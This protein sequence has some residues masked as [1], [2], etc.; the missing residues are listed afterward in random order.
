MPWKPD[1][2]R[3]KHNKSLTPAQAKHA[4]AQANAI[5]RSGGDEGVAIATANKYAKRHPAKAKRDHGT[6]YEP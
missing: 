1:E 3:R 2:F 5:I 4:A 6:K